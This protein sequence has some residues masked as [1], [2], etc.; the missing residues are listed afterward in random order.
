[1]RRPYVLAQS[2]ELSLGF[3]VRASAAVFAVILWTNKCRIGYYS[4]VYDEVSLSTTEC[5]GASPYFCLIHWSDY[6][7]S[8][9]I[10][11]DHFLL[12]NISLLCI[13][14]CFSRMVGHLHNIVHRVCACGLMPMTK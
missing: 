11:S 2:G 6:N 1:M 3:C 14:E 12:Q 4:A 9:L 13:V 8:T 10:Y 5:S 7:L